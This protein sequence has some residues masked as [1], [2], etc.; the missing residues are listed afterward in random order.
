MVSP[1]ANRLDVEVDDGIDRVHPKGRQGRQHLC[2]VVYAVE[3]PQE[4]NAVADVVVEP[5]GEFDCEK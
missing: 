4:R 3:L 5:I 2:F 1:Q